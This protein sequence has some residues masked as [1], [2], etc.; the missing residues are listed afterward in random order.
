MATISFDLLGCLVW[1]IAKLVG[2]CFLDSAG[3]GS[4]LSF[5]LRRNCPG[6]LGKV[7]PPCLKCQTFVTRICAISRLW[8]EFLSWMCHLFALCRWI[9]V[10]IK[11]LDIA[12]SLWQVAGEIY[13]RPFPRE[14]HIVRHRRHCSAVQLVRSHRSSRLLLA[15]SSADVLIWSNQQDTLDYLSVSRVRNNLVYLVWSF[16][17]K[18]WHMCCAR[19]SWCG[20]S[21][22]RL[23]C[24]VQFYA[25]K[26]ELRLMLL[27]LLRSE[28]SQV[29]LFENYLF[30]VI[31]EESRESF[32]HLIF[33]KQLVFAQK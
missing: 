10:C 5:N 21:Q 18:D 23:A 33:R 7:W 4:E 19:V 16:W 30:I 1:F 20:L 28:K 25:T 8:L 9:F 24:F 6:C 32:C 15:P 12:E 26:R 3:H 13:S 2:K 22:L 14:A 11:F 31:H 17:W 27:V 29:G